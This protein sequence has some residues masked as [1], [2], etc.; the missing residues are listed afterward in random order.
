MNERILVGVSGGIDSLACLKL[1]LEDFPNAKIFAHH[2]EFHNEQKRGIVETLAC[3]ECV[4]WFKTNYRDFEYTESKIEFT[5]Y[6]ASTWAFIGPAIAIA[7]KAIN[8]T[9]ICDGRRNTP[10]RTEGDM[11]PQAFWDYTAPTYRFY[12]PNYIGYFPVTSLT[13]REV[14]EKLPDT[15]RDK[16]WSCRK[17]NRV[18]IEWRPCGKCNSCMELRDIRI[19]HPIRVYKKI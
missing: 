16:Y 11:F 13:K 10:S 14:Y 7:A 9:H 18:N 19:Q 3:R 17:P 4:D 2:V 15:L 8:A 1:A 12:N 6:P 5:C